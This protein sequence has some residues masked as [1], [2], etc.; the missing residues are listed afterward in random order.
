MQCNAT[1]ECV[2]V[3][4]K[5]NI[6]H[7]RSKASSHRHLLYQGILQ[8]ASPPLLALLLIASR[9]WSFPDIAGEPIWYDATLESKLMPCALFE[10]SPLESVRLRFIIIRSSVTKRWQ[11][12]V[13]FL[14]CLSKVMTT[15]VPPARAS[16][17]LLQL[18]NWRWWMVSW[19]FV[20]LFESW[21]LVF[22]SFLHHSL[23][24][25]LH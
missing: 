14:G 5:G 6:I 20:S 9:L 4:L 12:S 11:G 17:V 2:W 7:R 18:L 24:W 1:K 8:A 22:R 23:H 16:R 10:R 3:Q 25:F 13:Q 21:K 19:L 15:V